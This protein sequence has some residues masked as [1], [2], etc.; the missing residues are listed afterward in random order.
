VVAI[1]IKV[2]QL[3][4]LQLQTIFSAMRDVGM[5]KWYF[6]TLTLRATYIPAVAELA[7]AVD[8]KSTA[9]TGLQVRVLSAGL[10]FG[11]KVAVTAY[12]CEQ[13]HLKPQHAIAVSLQGPS[14]LIF[15]F[16]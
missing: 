5:G 12:A 4:F 8:L 1:Q 9:L 13:T 10:G 2:R 16:C 6:Y 7:Y 14:H 11:I 15:G 3:N